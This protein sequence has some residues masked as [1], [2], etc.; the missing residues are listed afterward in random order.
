MKTPPCARRRTAGFTLIEI[1]VVLLLMGLLLTFLLPSFLKAIQRQKLLSA[2]QQ[3]AIVLRMA[4]LQ[5]IKAAGNTVVQI[6][7]TKGTVTAFSDP[8]NNQT[9]DAGESMLG[10]VDLPKGV[11]FMAVDGFTSPP[12]PAVA[13]F[14]S[15][16]SV[17]A[18]GAFRVQNTAGDQIEA[19]VLTAT[20]GRVVLQKYDGTSQWLT[21]GEGPK[22][23]KW[24]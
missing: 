22:A 15:N 2:A 18:P 5:A 6:D 12:N 11:T 14:S 21:N 10:R 4:R 8:N 19:R 24:N 17:A 20:S 13:I 3:T 16:G 9:L 1:L 23:W 7:T